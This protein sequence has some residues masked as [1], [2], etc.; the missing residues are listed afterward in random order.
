[1]KLTV[2]CNAGILLEKDGFGLLI[3]GISRDH[4]GF[5]G[6]DNG[7]YADI[8]QK[9]GI[10]SSCSALI[11]THCHP[12]HY[13]AER[14]QVAQRELNTCR[15][16][17]PDGQTPASGTMQ[18]GPFAV[19][20]RETPHMIHNG[21]PVR[22]FVFLICDG[23]RQL[24]IASDSLPDARMHREILRGVQPDAI[25]VN[26]VHLSTPD[27]KAW[28]LE[29]APKHTVVYHIPIDPADQTGMRRKA[30]RTAARDFHTS[31]TL[32]TEHPMD[33]GEI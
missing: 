2:I 30:M 23:E 1:M 14:V 16:F 25:F 7:Q 19:G 8:L 28:L 33:L 15:F 29:L 4:V 6:L 13:D 21:D 10:F 24:Y 32:V 17:I 22:H 5:S 12:D 9:N 3:D 18:F 11:F 31:V 27:T 26:P 20:Y